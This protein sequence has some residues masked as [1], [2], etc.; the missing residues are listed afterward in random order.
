VR[1]HLYCYP[2]NSKQT[3]MPLPSE[4]L[5]CKTLKLWET[6]IKHKSTWALVE[7]SMNEVNIYYKSIFC[8]IGIIHEDKNAWALVELT[9]TAGSYISLG[10][11]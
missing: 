9:K 2:A 6:I 4:Q 5:L 1:H 7:L 10:P 3:E 8:S 11:I